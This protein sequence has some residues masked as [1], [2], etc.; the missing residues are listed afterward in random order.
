MPLL[1]DEISV[2]PQKLY[3]TY[4]ADYE[5]KLDEIND[6]A[7]ILM[8]YIYD[9]VDNIQTYM[10]KC[11][12]MAKSNKCSKKILITHGVTDKY[13]REHFIDDPIKLT[14]DFIELFD[15]V[16]IGHIHTPFD[17][18]QGKTIVISPGAMIDYQAYVDRT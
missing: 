18:K 2:V 3:H 16:I 11:A 4:F 10:N 8:P 6:I 15:L 9:T 17:Y 14:D 13:F 12:D 7:F 1:I 5:L